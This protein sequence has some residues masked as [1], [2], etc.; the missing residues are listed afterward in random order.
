MKFFQQVYEFR[1]LFGD[2]EKLTTKCVHLKCGIE[3]NQTCLNNG[4]FPKYCHI[5]ILYIFGSI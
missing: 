2:I 5:Y 4:I 3:Y 1:K